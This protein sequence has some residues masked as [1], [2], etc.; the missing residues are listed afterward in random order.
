[1]KKL[2]IFGTM[3]LLLLSFISTYSQTKRN[4]IWTINDSTGID[5]TDLQNVVPANTHVLKN[6][7]YGTAS[8]ADSSGNLLMYSNGTNFW[9][10]NNFLCLNSD[11]N[12]S[13]L[14][15]KNSSFFIPSQLDSSIYFYFKWS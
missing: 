13:C 14:W 7:V 9:G 6:R 5:F 15:C 8:I 1:M 12:Y 10:R 2:K 3:A 4:R 11:S